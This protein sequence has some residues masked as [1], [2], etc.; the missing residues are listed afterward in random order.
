LT[1]PVLT[2][3]QD[4][5]PTIIAARA[6]APRTLMIRLRCTFP[7]RVNP[8]KPK[9]SQ[10]AARELFRLRWF[11]AATLAAATVRT[12]LTALLPGVREAGA[13]E[14]LRVLGNPEQARAIALLKAPDCGVAVTVTVPDPPEEIVKKEGLVP[15]IKVG[16]VGVGGG[17]GGAGFGEGGGGGGVGDATQLDVNVTGAEMWLLRLGFPTACTKSVY[18]SLGTE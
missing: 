13:N 12:E 9:L 18:V 17:G 10:M 7:I 6:Q 14:Q 8:N 5:A 1:G 15:K 11:V 2:P 16:L 3:P 4:M